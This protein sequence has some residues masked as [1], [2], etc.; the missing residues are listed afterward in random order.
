MAP[1]A[2]L[3]DMFDTLFMILKN[4]EFYGASLKRMYGFLVSNG[5]NVPF[6]S[7]NQTYISERDALYAV[8]D[9]NWE[10]PHFN[11]RVAK[12]YKFW[13]TTTNRFKPLVSSAT[14]RSTLNY[15]LC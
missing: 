5:I 13:I 7:F 11:I 14:E 4:H 3:F 12:P 6:D 1:K 10:D 9:K 2:V 15:E 8:A